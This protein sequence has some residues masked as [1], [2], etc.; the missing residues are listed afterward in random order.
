MQR[1]EDK[2]EKSVSGDGMRIGVV[3][4]EFNWDITGKML[5]ASVDFLKSH[6]VSGEDI[7][8]VKVPGSFELPLMC[9]SMIEKGRFNALVALGCVIKGETDHYYYVAGEASRGIMS[10]MIETGIPIGFGVITTNNLEQAK[11]RSSGKSNKGLEA[12]EAALLM[13]NNFK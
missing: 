10:V 1:E 11:E 6:G 4:A 8:V 7:E 12:A 3:V 2:K 5:D 13:V 9:K